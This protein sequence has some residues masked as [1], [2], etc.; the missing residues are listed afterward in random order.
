MP[1]G[2]DVPFITF[3][4]GDK[5]ANNFLCCQ[6]LGLELTGIG[7]QRDLLWRIKESV[8]TPGSSIQ[9]TL[10]PQNTLVT[11]QRARPGLSQIQLG[12]SEQTPSPGITT[13]SPSLPPKQLLLPTSLLLLLSRGP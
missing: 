4:C 5:K 2:A 11:S 1:L 7:Y 10:D 12:S 8:G 6:D 13:L 9:P 3:I